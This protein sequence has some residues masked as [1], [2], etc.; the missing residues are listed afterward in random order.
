MDVRMAVPVRSDGRTTKY[1]TAK[2]RYDGG[3][4]IYWFVLYVI[5]SNE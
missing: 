2:N 3:V 5:L 4:R 1:G